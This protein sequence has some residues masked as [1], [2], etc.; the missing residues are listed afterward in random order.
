M[1]Q[2]PDFL[3]FNVKKIYRP[4]RAQQIPSRRDTNK[5]IKYSIKKLVKGKYEILTEE[6][7]IQPNRIQCYKP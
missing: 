5:M 1:Y 6:K 3:N 7:K 2:G 4:N